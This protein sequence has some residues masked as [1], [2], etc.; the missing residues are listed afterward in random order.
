MVSTNFS[1]IRRMLK[2]SNFKIKLIFK[3]QIEK[4]SNWATYEQKD[5]EVSA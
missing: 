3:T 4:F 2:D 1:G 5:D